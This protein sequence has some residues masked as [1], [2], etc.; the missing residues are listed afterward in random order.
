VNPCE[1]KIVDPYPLL[2]QSSAFELP[3][4]GKGKKRGGLESRIRR[5][6]CHSSAT[7]A[8][9]VSAGDPGTKEKEV[10]RKKKRVVAIH[11]ETLSS[12]RDSQNRRTARIRQGNL[13]LVS[14]IRGKRKEGGGEVSMRAVHRAP[15]ARRLTKKGVK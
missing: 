8:L 6:T 14:F 15:S 2:A 11:G 10:E 4:Q 1:K 5:P 7:I 12:S 9:V 3:L 13:W